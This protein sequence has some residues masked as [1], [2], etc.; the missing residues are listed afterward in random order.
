MHFHLALKLL[1][2][3]DSRVT[4]THSIWIAIGNFLDLIQML[5]SLRVFLN[6]FGRFK[7][8]PGR[9]TL[10]WRV[11]TLLWREA[12]TGECG[13]EWHCMRRAESE[14]REQPALPIKL[15]FQNNK[16]LILK[17]IDRCGACLE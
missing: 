1:A 2:L 9:Y 15:I 3:Q 11:Q 13:I 6:T 4:V 10:C 12:Q 5:R 8:F 17:L 16:L 7:T 14:R